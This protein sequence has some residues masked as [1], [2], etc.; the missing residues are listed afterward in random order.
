MLKRAREGVYTH[1]EAQRGVPMSHLVRYFT[2]RKDHWSINQTIK[3][4]VD[5][6]QQNLMARFFGVSAFS[7]SI[8]CRNVLI[9]FAPEQK[10]DVLARWRA[11]S[12]PTAIWCSARRKA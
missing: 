5:F 1:F 6:R 11:R 3:A 7:T 2:K 12:R 8:F 9:Y 4:R 10:R